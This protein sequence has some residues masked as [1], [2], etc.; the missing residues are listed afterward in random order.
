[1]E[2]FIVRSSV[3]AR[4]MACGV[5]LTA[6]GAAALGARVPVVAAQSAGAS[7]APCI[8]AGHG[9]GTIPAITFGRIGGNIR[10]MQVAIYGDGT[11]SYQGAAT[12]LTTTYTI[13]PTAVQGLQRLA[14]AEGFWSMPAVITSTPR[15]PDAAALY[16]T[17]RAGCATTT[18]RVEVH[19][20]APAGFT[21]L[22]DTL[23]AATAI[24]AQ[25]VMAPTAGPTSGPTDQGSPAMGGPAV[26]TVAESA[27][28]LEYVVG[29][30]FLLNLGADYQ[31]DVQVSDQSVV[32][33]K[34]NVTVVRGAQ[35]IYVAR[36]P[37]RTTLIANGKMVCAAG[38][39]CPALVLHVQIQ[40]VVLPLL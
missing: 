39:A 10:P 6:F 31:W 37:G 32:H 18:H 30:S 2:G 33:R 36:A 14:Q 7:A 38:Q 28:T 23:Q 4:I 9:A 26:V 24:P 12:P 22:Y 19:G 34:V 5:L 21:E 20:M 13:L 1:M 29:Q 35:G 40:L 25:P 3:L 16:I 27:H 17:V 8:P 11:I 15:N